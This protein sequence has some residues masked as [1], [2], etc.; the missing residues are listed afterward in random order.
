MGGIHPPPLR[1]YGTEKK[2]DPERIKEMTE[3]GKLILKST[4]KT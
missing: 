1:P 2:R 4:N 3:A